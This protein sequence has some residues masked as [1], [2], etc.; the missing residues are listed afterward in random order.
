MQLQQFLRSP[1]GQLTLGLIRSLNVAAIC[2][3]GI[4]HGYL[5]RVEHAAPAPIDTPAYTQTK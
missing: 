2:A 5:F 4:W 1:R 3:L